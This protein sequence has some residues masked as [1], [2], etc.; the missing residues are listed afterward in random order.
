MMLLIR[1]I[2]GTA[3]SHVE[4]SSGFTKIVHGSLLLLLLLKQPILIVIVEIQW[5]KCGVISAA[6]I[7]CL[8]E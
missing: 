5:R 2:A 3:D 7:S 8:N 1:Q 4:L 6:T